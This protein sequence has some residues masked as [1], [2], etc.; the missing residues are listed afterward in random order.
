MKTGWVWAIG[1]GLVVGG[2]VLGFM[3]RDA[4]MGVASVVGETPE[5]LRFCEHVIVEKRLMKKHY[6]RDKWFEYES[7]AGPVVMINFHV[8]GGP[9][10]S[11]SGSALCRFAPSSQ[12]L[13]Y[14]KLTAVVLDGAPFDEL[15]IQYA[16]ATWTP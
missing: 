10:N 4:V 2:V 9:Y 7:S 3:G 14:Q 15:A 5:R 12:G 16:N 1:A 8:E 11:D 6:V 13:L